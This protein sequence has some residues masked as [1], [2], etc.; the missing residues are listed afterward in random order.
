MS[1]Y[2][3]KN[4]IV[5]SLSLFF[6]VIIGIYSSKA[7]WEIAELSGNFDKSEFAVGLAGYRFSPNKPVKIIVGSKLLS[8]NNQVVIGSIPFYIQ[9]TGEKTS[10]ELITT[11]QYREL[12]KRKT[13]LELQPHMH[14]QYGAEDIKFQYTEANG[15]SF[16]SYKVESLN[17][18]VAF[19]VNEPLFFRK[20][21]ITTEVEAE[22]KDGVKVQVPISIEYVLNFVLTVHAKDIFAQSF[23]VQ[24]SMN[25]VNSMDELFGE[26][27][28][29]HIEAEQKQVRQK[30]SFFGYLMALIFTK[31]KSSLYL[32]HVPLEEVNQRGYTIFI[33]QGKH[34]VKALDYELLSWDL[35]FGK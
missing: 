16:I 34:T 23:P 35:L 2:E 31:S 30:Y 14:G 10:Q 15:T 26:P 22:T 9:S 3:K 17:P 33:S 4:F 1:K 5:A 21:S 7:N 20:T 18:G 19:T 13:L 8:N 29:T 32:V 27:L 28:H 6:G 11:F 25:S 24:V 12:F